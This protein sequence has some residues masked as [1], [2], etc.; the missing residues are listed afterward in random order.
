[1]TIGM[2]RENGTRNAFRD[3][4]IVFTVLQCTSPKATHKNEKKISH[5]ETPKDIFLE[6]KI[7]KKTT[8]IDRF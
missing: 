7:S 4:V 8:Q 5:R 1:M 3:D 6:G 2:E